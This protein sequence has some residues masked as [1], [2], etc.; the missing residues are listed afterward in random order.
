MPDHGVSHR[1]C[2]VNEQPLGRILV[3][4]PLHLGFILDFVDPDT[5]EAVRIRDRPK[6]D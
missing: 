2:L 3:K 5:V 4:K 1:R 6:D